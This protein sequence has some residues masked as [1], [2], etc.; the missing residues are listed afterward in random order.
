[1][2]KYRKKIQELLTD[3]QFRDLAEIAS[4]EGKRLGTLVREAVEE[5]HLKRKRER[6][7]AQAVERI[8][9]GPTVPVTKTWEEMEEELA[10]LHAVA[11]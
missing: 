2:P 11:E 10:R 7:I 1:M 8:L 6:Q 5:Y 4:E 9:S 3:D